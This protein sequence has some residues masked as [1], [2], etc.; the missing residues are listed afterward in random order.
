MPSKLRSCTKALSVL[1]PQLPSVV[2][3]A[4]TTLAPA[5]YV[6]PVGSTPSPL[7]ITD[8]RC[9]W[10]KT[11]EAGSNGPVRFTASGE[12]RSR[13]ANERRLEAAER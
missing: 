1:E 4:P 8:A 2:R 6:T 7:R 5:W 11:S 10:L 12:R 3:P 9:A 13:V